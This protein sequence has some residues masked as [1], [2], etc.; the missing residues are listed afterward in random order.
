M[1]FKTT[2]INCLCGV[3][4]L[5]K[6]PGKFTTCLHLNEVLSIKNNDSITD[7]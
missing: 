7:V 3:C 4:L 2:F 5:Y 6:E 1:Y